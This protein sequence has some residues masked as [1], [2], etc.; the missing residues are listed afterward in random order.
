MINDATAKLWCDRE[1]RMTLHSY[2]GH[3]HIGNDPVMYP[4]YTCES[5]NCFAEKILVQGTKI[6]PGIY[7]TYENQVKS[8][9]IEY[10]IAEEIFSRKYT[11]LSY[12]IPLIIF[13]IIGWILAQN[14]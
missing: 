11:I 1:N 13:V 6:Q 9:S 7:V 2:I 5:G 12:M 3:T 4:V 8:E 10:S 14:S